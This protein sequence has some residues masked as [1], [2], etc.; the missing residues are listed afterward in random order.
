MLG[1]FPPDVSVSIEGADAQHYL[2]VARNLLF[3]ALHLHIADGG[4][5]VQLVLP[6]P[7]GG[8]IRVKLIGNQKIVEIIT[9]STSSSEEE[10]PVLEQPP[11]TQ[12]YAAIMYSGVVKGGLLT[13]DA[14]GRTVLD[15]FR[16]TGDVRE[17]LRAAARVR[18]VRQA[19][20]RRQ[21]RIAIP[22]HQAVV[23]LR[24]DEARGERTARPRHR[25]RQ[26][27]G[28]PDRQAAAARAPR[29]PRTVSEFTWSVCHGIVKVGDKQHWLV[30][31]HSNRGVH[32]MPLPLFE[33]TMTRA[34]HAE[35]K[36]RGDLDTVR[37]LDE[38]GGLPSG[39]T[40]PTDDAS[41]RRRS[42]AATSSS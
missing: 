40:F 23:F 19:R 35:K 16:P 2:G 27:E 22:L 38:F 7:T 21:R 26:L 34:Y 6:L 11:G 32:A 25:H 30:E 13:T 29:D 36:G 18:E 12:D 8:S 24:R 39:E 15:S 41:S 31:I 33:N 17:G 37:V 10:Q 42:R 14:Q 28:I 4:K 9:T 5:P 3:R 20:S 1:Y